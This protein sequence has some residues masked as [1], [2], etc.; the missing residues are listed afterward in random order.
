MDDFFYYASKVILFFPVVLVILALIFKF[1]QS[2]KKVKKVIIPTQRLTPTAN[3]VK[4]NNPL[5]FNL[6]GPFVCNFSDKKASISAFI[7][8]KKIF[9]KKQEKESVIN[10]L[11]NNDCL[12]LWEDKKY[13]GD[14]VCGIS[15]YLSFFEN[16]PS[17]LK[18]TN[19]GFTSDQ[20]LNFLNFCQKKEIENDKIFEVPVRVL[21]KNKSL[22]NI[23]K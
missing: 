1:N 20:S 11:V 18:L 3:P 19:F 21:F 9:I 6:D 2:D 15:S 7:K 14:K 23:L 13:N 5:N 16:F 4:K 8:D 22:P 12:Y 17:F 10:F